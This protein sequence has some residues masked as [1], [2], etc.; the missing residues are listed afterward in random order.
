MVIL[1][2]QNDGTSKRSPL[3]L[4]TFENVMTALKDIITSNSDHSNPSIS[5][6]L[7]SGAIKKN[8]DYPRRS[9]VFLCSVIKQSTFCTACGEEGHWAKDRDCFLYRN[10]QMWRNGELPRVGSTTGCK[11]ANKYFKA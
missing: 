7:S 9:I 2:K 1:K 3:L 10:S 8:L 11:L 5:A 6:L 4:L